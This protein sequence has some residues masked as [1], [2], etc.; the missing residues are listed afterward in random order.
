MILFW[1]SSGEVDGVTMRWS[2][3]WRRGN[4]TQRVWWWWGA[5][6][7]SGETADLRGRRAADQTR[8]LIHDS[9]LITC[10]DFMH[11]TSYDAVPSLSCV[12]RLPNTNFLSVSSGSLFHPIL[13]S[14]A[15][16]WGCSANDSEM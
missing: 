1:K 16:F 3:I 6:R 10:Y 14:R 13:T 4:L 12:A 8:L 11:T 9:D 7:L 15:S 5:L 2:V